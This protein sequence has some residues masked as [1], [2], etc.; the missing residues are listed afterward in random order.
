MGRPSIG[1]RE[2]GPG[3]LRCVVMKLARLPLVALLCALTALVASGC[4]SSAGSGG[5][6][7]PAALV[8]ANAVLYGEATLHPEG[9][10][11]SDL[12]AALRKIL[13]TE[14]PGAQIQ[15]WLNDAGKG[16]DVT[17]KDDIE[18]W[19]GDRAGAA[20]T[21]LKSEDD[22]DFVAVIGS[23]DDGKAQ[24][25]IDKQRDTVAR[26]YKDVDYRFDRKESTAATVLDHNVVIG[27][28]PGLKAAIDASKGDSLAESNSL[29][30]VRSK[31]TDD[32]I[33]L[34]Y[35]D[36]QGLIRAI[37]QASGGGSP[38][39][40]AL[41]QS[42]AATAP[43]T[44]GAALQAQGDALRVDAVSLG[45]P[46]SGSAGGSGGEIVKGLPGDSWLAVGI[47]KSGERLNQMLETVGDAGG[48]TGAGLEAL[49]GQVQKQVG[50]DLREDVLSWMGDAGLFVSGT[51]VSDLG[52][53][54]V[55]KTS[56]PAK[57]KRVIG[58]VRRL[59]REDGSAK[60]SDLDVQGVDDGISVRSSDF[61]EVDIA[62]AGDKFIV[63]VGRSALK[64]AIA[65]DQ[66]LGSS[67]AFTDA[68]GKLGGGL[69]PAFFL[70]L[71]RVFGLVEPFV[72]GDA[73]YQKAKPYLNVFGAVVAGAKDEGDGVTR[74]RFVVTLK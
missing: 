56:D 15:K 45:T 24:D 2:G 18:P 48:I 70:D 41:L 33:A 6:N 28:E 34:L 9:K 46:K 22:A 61:P 10:Q 49:L 5:D 60:V 58:V 12:D 57:T 51:S 26:T 37:G 39:T 31:V 42:F 54:L 72:T 43:K 21:S 30:A 17:Y 74:S 71:Q 73:D 62:L 13:R 64:Q 59:A 69:Q 40:G 23:K 20:V 55:I 35:L 36:V 27:T 32:R 66:P 38:E 50:L 53:A 11:A 4:G 44:I 14:N 63:A 47:A 52:G 7:D 3:A 1:Q 8:P 68:A 25:L 65:P 29:E 67:A 19:L 16:E